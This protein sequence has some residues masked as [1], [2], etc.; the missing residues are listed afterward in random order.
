MH[1]TV[2]AEQIVLIDAALKIGVA[3][4]DTRYEMTDHIATALEELSGDFN[5]K[6][7]VYIVFHKKE[8]KRTNRKFMFIAFKKSLN[9][10]FKSS[11]KPW[12]FLLFVSVFLIAMLLHTFL[13]RG[14]VT[15]LLFL[16]YVVLSCMASMP[17]A[18]KA[19][20][21]KDQFSAISGFGILPAPLFYITLRMLKWQKE[22]ASDALV[23]LCFAAIISFSALLLV[24]AK[25]LNK[26]YKL[27]YNA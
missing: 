5:E 14:D 16:S 17:N 25:Q 24:T 10:L 15:L 7:K 12:F 2:N 26:E 21:D 4:I 23:M 13:D 1:K 6:L 3:Y 9:Y 20:V 27:R 19:I 11:R 8:L 18:W 22:M